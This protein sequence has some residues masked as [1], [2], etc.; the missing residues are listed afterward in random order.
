ME[1]ERFAEGFAREAPQCTP[2]RRA[3]PAFVRAVAFA[4]YEDGLRE[5]LHLLKYERVRSLARP[6]GRML[7]SA[8]ELLE[9]EINASATGSVPDELLVVAVPLFRSK[10]RARGFNH[11]EL[12]A[13]EAVEELKRRRP[14]WRLRPA[15]RALQR[16]RETD[17]QFGLSTRARRLNLREAF[18]VA[19]PGAVAGRDVLLIDDIY[20]TG[21]T[22]RVCAQALLSAGARRVLVATLARAQVESVAMWDAGQTGSSLPV[23]GFGQVP[24]EVGGYI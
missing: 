7:A 24:I 8:V 3:A 22:A 14:D 11:A 21:A 16:V 20:T 10:E 17:S 2:C 15:H 5:M 19:D 18:A 23:T 6:L 9:G 13:D 12:L 1:D 4:V